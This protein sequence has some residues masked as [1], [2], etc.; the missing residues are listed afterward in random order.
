MITSSYFW[1]N[2]F[3]IAL[4]TFSIRFS[5]IALSRKFVIS[6]RIKEILSFIPAAVLP[7]IIIPIVFYHK[8]EVS[9]LYEKE[10][11]FILVFAIAICYLTRSMFLTIL[12]G[13]LALY[14]LTQLIG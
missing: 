12:S 1:L 4:G 3:V 2:V 6:D 8:G 14:G 9:W 5:L 11:A 7:A 10:R 13:L